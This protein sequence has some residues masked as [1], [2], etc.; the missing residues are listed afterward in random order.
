MTGAVEIIDRACDGAARARDMCPVLDPYFVA[1]EGLSSGVSAIR[2][3]MRERGRC[4]LPPTFS[5]HGAAPH[6]RWYQSG[7]VVVCVAGQGH[8]LS[9]CFAR[10]RGPRRVTN[11]SYG[12]RRGDRPIR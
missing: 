3:D 6:R 4:R 5:E 2:M 1:A 7:V 11:P 9:G 12:L 10:R 8:T